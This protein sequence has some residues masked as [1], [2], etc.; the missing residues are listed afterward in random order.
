ME[1]HTGSADTHPDRPNPTPPTSVPFSR[2]D[3]AAKLLLSPLVAVVAFQIMLIGILVA[4][5]TPAE[6]LVLP[7]VLAAGLRLGYV[8]LV[9]LGYGRFLVARGPALVLNAEGIDDRSGPAAAGL[10]PWK[11]LVSAQ[12]ADIF[13][14]RGVALYVE[15]PEDLLL[16]ASGLRWFLMQCNFELFGTPVHIPVE[17]TTITANTLLDRI[18]ARIEVEKA[19][20]KAHPP[21]DGPL[22]PG[23][24]FAPRPE[25]LTPYIENPASDRSRN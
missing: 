12:P 10:I 14:H 2:R 25:Y 7:P 9:Y 17:T 4:L 6:L 24:P 11:N 19:W 1:H 21:A 3:V 23:S 15:N 13:A 5:I 22:R 20:K 18:Y 16:H 8:A